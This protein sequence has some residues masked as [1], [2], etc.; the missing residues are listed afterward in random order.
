MEKL[1]IYINSLYDGVTQVIPALAPR[2]RVRQLLLVVRRASYVRQL[3]LVVR[4]A[5]Y[6]GF[7]HAVL[8]IKYNKCHITP[9][10][11]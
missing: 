5:S 8:E 1:L 7:K 9:N 3:L 2:Y 4:R 10:Y 11:D 6:F